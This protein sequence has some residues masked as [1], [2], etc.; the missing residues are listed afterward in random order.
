VSTPGA[1]EHFADAPDAELLRAMLN[2]T[3]GAGPFEKA[4]A[5]LEQRAVERQTAFGRRLVF[6]TWGLVAATL[7]LFGATLVEIF[8]LCR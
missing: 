1:H 7:A 2:N 5:L 8:K 4:K 3:P 6:A